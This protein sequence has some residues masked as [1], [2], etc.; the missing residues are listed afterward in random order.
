M[1]KYGDKQ[2]SLPTATK[3]DDNRLDGRQNDC[4]LVCVCVCLM[5]HLY[6]HCVMN[7]DVIVN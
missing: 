4:F 6:H 5:F 2:R 3:N 7:K 1:N